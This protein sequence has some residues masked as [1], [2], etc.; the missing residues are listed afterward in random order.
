MPRFSIL[1]TLATLLAP[2]G[3]GAGL[4]YSGEP[5]AELPSQWRGY[6]LDQ[7][8]LR[9]IALPP[10]QAAPP[11]LARRRYEEAA[12]RLTNRKNSLSADEAADLGAVYVRLGDPGRAIGVL[13]DALR[14]YPGQFHLV[15]NLGTAWQMQ[16]DLTQAAAYLHEAVRLAPAGLRNAEACHLRLVQ[17]RLRSGPAVAGLADLFGIRY[18][19]EDGRYHPGQLAAAE[20]RRLPPDAVAVVQRLGLWLP[21]DAR[22]L[23]QL[24]ELAGAAG[25][26]RTA[27]MLMD[28]CVT[29]LGLDDPELLEHRRL[30]RLAADAVRGDAL[31]STHAAHRNWL[32]PKSRRPLLA[33]LDAPAPPAIRPDGV[34]PL[35]WAILGETALG[36]K[37]GPRFPAFLQQLDGRQV[38]LTG[39]MQPLGDDADAA[40]FLMV[41]APVGCWYCETPEI[42]GIVHVTA[43][44]TRPVVPVRAQVR[45]TGRLH[46]NRTDP[47]RFL[48]TITNATV[49]ETD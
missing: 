29:E 27:A 13:R 46:L 18:V 49:T 39:F 28:G 48:Y 16:G 14:R 2:T 34:N 22:L 21:A 23:W 30:M 15:A 35:S 32:R 4:Y 43:D 36:G 44:R 6:V 24:A 33:R 1:V 19:G 11:N 7:R 17:S 20:R 38:S 40:A 8:M 26:V 37:D 3:A 41:E 25:D 31:Q 47:E 42:T 10:R 5:M 45:V 9:T 12:A